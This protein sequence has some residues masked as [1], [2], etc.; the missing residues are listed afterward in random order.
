MSATAVQLAGDLEGL[1]AAAR[2]RLPRA[3]FDYVE[4]G[5]EEERTMAANRAAFAAYELRCNIL[6][7]VAEVDTSV[8]LFGHRLPLPLGLAP[9]GYTRMMHPEG[10]IAVARAAAAAGLPYGLSTVGTVSIEDLAATGH[11]QLWLQLYVFRERAVSLGLV[12]RAAAAGMAALELTVDTATAGQRS[13]DLRNGL[14]IPP[15]L[16]LRTIADILGHVGYWSAMLT[17]APFRFANLG[18]APGTVARISTRFDP[19]LDW[20]FFAEL[21]NRWPRTL[22]V[23]GPV[24]PSDAARAIEAGADAVHLSNHGGRQLDRCVTPL[25]LLPEV[26]RA[27]GDSATVLLDSGLRSGADLALALSLGADACLVGRPYLYGLAAAGEDGVRRVIELFSAGLT[28][29]M[30]L[31]GVA[32]VAELRARRDELVVRR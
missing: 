24:G 22:I 2:R 16:S 4:G 8:T 28:R 32:S 9:T 19:T 15:Q 13:R 30:R 11:D 12:E 3:V 7:E 26:R 10:E 21:R 29:T 6:A 20:G 27:V 1:R 17:A 14:T 23:K 5:C 25:D 31:L 18:N